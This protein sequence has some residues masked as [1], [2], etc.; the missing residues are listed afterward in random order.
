MCDSPSNFKND[1][2]SPTN[3]R[4]FS[5][6]TDIKSAFEINYMPLVTCKSSVLNQGVVRKYVPLYDNSSSRL[7][8]TNSTYGAMECE[9][10]TQEC[11]GQTLIAKSRKIRAKMAS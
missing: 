8:N 4:Y 10:C 2:W 9:N 7:S 1:V 3:K 11:I 5:H 6:N